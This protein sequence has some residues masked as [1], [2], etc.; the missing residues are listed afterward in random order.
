MKEGWKGSDFLSFLKG[1]SQESV[2]FRDV[3]MVFS[4]DLWAHLSPEE[5][6]LYRDVMLDTCAQLVL[7]GCWTYKAEV[8]SSLRQGRDPRMLEGEATSAAWPEPQ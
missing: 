2:K 4:P 8:I 1:I 6:Q 3:A 5:R 7:L